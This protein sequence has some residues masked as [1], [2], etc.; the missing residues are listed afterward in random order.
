MYLFAPDQ[1]FIRLLDRAFILP[2][3]YQDLQSWRS[4]KCSVC[5][6]SS[7]ISDLF[8]GEHWNSASQSKTLAG[9]TASRINCFSDSG[10]DGEILP[11]SFAWLA[12][13]VE[14]MSEL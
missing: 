1:G 12:P 11:T 5:P 13:N 9:P 4:H 8:W 2:L 7:Q 3:S 10:S 14:G 6:W